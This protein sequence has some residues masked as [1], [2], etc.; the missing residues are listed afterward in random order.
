MISDL[1]VRIKLPHSIH[2]KW[3]N[4]ASVRGLSLKAFVA[5]TVSAE[6]IR[7]GELN[8][9][10]VTPAATKPAPGE[11]VYDPSKTA[12]DHN[13]KGIPAFNL[14]PKSAT[15]RSVWLDDGEDDTEDYGRA[16]KSKI[17]STVTEVTPPADL[18]AAVGTWIDDDEEG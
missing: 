11:Y 8:V 7:T 17:P 6:L 16:S 13:W 1:E 10:S 9:T 5:A 15:K 2:Q 14:D 4:A 18:K 3:S 12:V